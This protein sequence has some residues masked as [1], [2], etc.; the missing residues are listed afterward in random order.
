MKFVALI[1][2]NEGERATWPEARQ[3]AELKAYFAY[4]AAL[5]DALVFG[6]ALEATSKA[7]TLR[8]AA[9]SS[10][11]FAVTN[12]QLLGLYLFEAPSLA[13]AVA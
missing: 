10:G 1:Y 2:G 11:P 4:D 3:L 6:E 5:K 8:G 13:R 9:R 12:D 7:M